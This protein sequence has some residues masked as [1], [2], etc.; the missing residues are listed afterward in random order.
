MRV[1]GS[2]LAWPLSTQDGL[3]NAIHGVGLGAHELSATLAVGAGY[4]AFGVS[5]FILSEG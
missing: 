5:A 3:G 2:G 4:K 1:M